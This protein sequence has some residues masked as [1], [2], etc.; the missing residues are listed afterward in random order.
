[1]NSEITVLVTGFGPFKNHEVNA[2]W[3][4][5][6]ELYKMKE[7]L[8]ERHNVRL[9]IE[10]IPVV[11]HHVLHRVPQLWKEHDPQI[12]VH[13]GVSHKAQCL[14]FEQKAHGFGYFRPD[15]NGEC[16]TNECREGSPAFLETGIDVKELCR[17]INEKNTGK[18]S[19]KA[20]ISVDAG[21]YLCEYIYYQSLCKNSERALFVHVPDSHVYTSE[22]TAKGLCEIIELLVDSIKNCK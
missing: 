11:Y 8:H 20:C 22:V 14:T 2:S 3:E 1:M 13:V 18:E 5:V 10:N 9:V 21:R 19:C 12:V 7:D 6:K 16:M 17:K 15:V 4:A